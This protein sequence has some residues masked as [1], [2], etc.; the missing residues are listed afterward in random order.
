MSQT[1]RLSRMYVDIFIIGRNNLPVC[2]SVG[3][4]GFYLPSFFMKIE[5]DNDSI[6]GLHLN[7][8]FKLVDT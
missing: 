1:T 6:N 4:R 2:G 8:N 3:H 7:I 5:V